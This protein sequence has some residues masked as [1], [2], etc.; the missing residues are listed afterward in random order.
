MIDTY[1]AALAA[2]ASMAKFG[3]VLAAAAAA[4][5][6]AAGLAN[7]KNIEKQEYEPP[8]AATG[9][10]LMGHSHAEG[11]TIIEAEGGEYITKKSR[12]KE[13]GA[14]L[15]NF[16]NSAPLAQVKEALGGM[17]FPEIP[18]PTLPRAVYADG[19]MVSQS[20]GLMGVM[21][22]INEKMGLLVEKNVEFNINVDPLAND[23]VKVSEIADTGKMIRSEV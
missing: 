10:L 15:F 4:A 11:G 13:L 22:K 16:L 1:S 5:A 20:S 6:V 14:G 8:K 19:G 3:P 7:V 9:G 2:Y 21:E 17:R 18:T 23:P 12:V